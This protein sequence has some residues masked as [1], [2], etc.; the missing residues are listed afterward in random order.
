MRLHR[1][2][3]PSLFIL[4]LFIWPIFAHA[5][6]QAGVDAYAQAP[7]QPFKEITGKDGAPM[8]LV[9]A[10]SFT[11]GSGE[12]KESGFSQFMRGLFESPKRSAEWPE[13]EQPAHEVE[14]DAFYLDQYEVTVERYQRFM[15]KTSRAQP[16]YW[17]QVELSRDAQKPVV[18]LNWDDARAY[19]EWA[20]KRLPTEA[21]W[22]KAARG[23]DTRTY[24]WGA[25]QPNSSTANFGK[26]FY[27]M[28]KLYAEKLKAVGSYERGKSPYEAYDMAGNVWEWV[29]D[30]YGRDYYSASPQKNPQGPSSGEYKVLRGG[31][32]THGPSDLRS[33]FRGRHYPAR[34]TADLG[35]R[36]AQDAP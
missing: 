18:G 9:P 35:V 15:S 5:D 26:G 12:S 30:W 19:C 4:F 13:K 17:E 34:R 25:S 2:L 16:E 3:T 31:S 21:E 33:A 22:E 1:T 27:E 23:T 10:G 20:E 36:C 29:G 28:E 14:L 32:W 11:M 8:V 6:F 24:P 7:S